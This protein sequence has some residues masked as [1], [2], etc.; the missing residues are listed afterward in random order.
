MVDF[1]AQARRKEAI[2][3]GTEAV[4]AYQK[5]RRN[6]SYLDPELQAG[7]AKSKSAAYRIL[8]ELLVEDDRLGAAEQVLDL[9]KEQELREVVRGVADSATAKVQ[10]VAL[11]SAEQKAE[12]GLALA[13][14][15]SVALMDVS[16]EYAT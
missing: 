4:N 13:E 15:S 6:I 1:R 5:L 2:F 16:I 9:L 14:D 7:F 10:P 8:A 3:F 12:G 11:T